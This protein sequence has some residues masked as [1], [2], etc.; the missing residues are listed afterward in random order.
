VIDLSQLGREAHSVR[1]CKLNELFRAEV[2]VHYSA[3][4]L[5]IESVVVDE[6]TINLDETVEQLA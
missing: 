2:A 3:N 6:E 5:D 1:E 4:V